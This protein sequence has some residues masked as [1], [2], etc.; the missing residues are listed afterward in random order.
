MLYK[1]CREFEQKVLGGLIKRAPS[2]Y[3]LYFVRG[4]LGQSLSVSRHK[5]FIDR[6][7]KPFSA[8]GGHFVKPLLK[9][10]VY[11]L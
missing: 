9:L 2:L 3:K 6:I 7:N 4:Q 5:G 8:R 10:S 11:K 1:Y